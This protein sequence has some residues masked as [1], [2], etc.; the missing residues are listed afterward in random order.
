[1]LQPVCICKNSSSSCSPLSTVQSLRSPFCLCRE[2][3]A[4]AHFE[5]SH[6]APKVS[7]GCLSMPTCGQ[8]ITCA[9]ISTR[10]AARVSRTSMAL[11]GWLLACQHSICVKRLAPHDPFGAPAAGQG[12]R[13]CIQGCG[14]GGA[15]ST[16]CCSSRECGK[17]ESMML[18]R[19]CSV[20][21]AWDAVGHTCWLTL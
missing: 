11:P 6:L 20:L 19:W 2:D 21:H 7:M 5:A 9:G 12:L 17:R 14:G 15:E 8:Q 10:C 13:D 18:S 1:M 4:G 3:A 16:P